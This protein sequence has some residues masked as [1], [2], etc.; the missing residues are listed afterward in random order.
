VREKLLAAGSRWCE[1]VAGKAA[2]RGR[3]R[4]HGELGDVGGCWRR[5]LYTAAGSK[6][7]RRAG[8]VKLGGAAARAGAGPRRDRAA[9]TA[10]SAAKQGREGRRVEL[11]RGRKHGEEHERERKLLGTRLLSRQNSEGF[12]A[13]MLGVAGCS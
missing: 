13:K 11:A 7:R 10:A 8:A 12:C 9:R 2:T 3:R 4:E 1:P 6:W 5:G